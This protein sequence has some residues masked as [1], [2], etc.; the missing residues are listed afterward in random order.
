MVGS[1]FSD[2]SPD[3]RPVNIEKQK[4]LKANSDLWRIDGVHALRLFGL[5]TVVVAYRW[6]IF[7]ALLRLNINC[8]LF[9][10][11]SEFIFLIRR[12]RDC[13]DDNRHTMNSK[14]TFPNLW[15]QYRHF[16]ELFARIRNF[17]D[18]DASYFGGSMHSLH[19]AVPYFEYNP[20]SLLYWMHWR[21]FLCAV[22]YSYRSVTQV[23]R[24][25]VHGCLQSR[26]AYSNL[27]DVVNMFQ[28]ISN[29][30]VTLYTSIAQL[31]SDNIKIYSS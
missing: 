29:N 7:S 25:I 23:H 4:F 20:R 21:V 15:L 16:F 6:N 10:A 18:V 3:I 17:L 30:R 26:S 1:A 13:D 31:Y 5:S 19:S 28:N 12:R 24:H 22:Q 27:G 14:Y 11:S 2:R 8:E 9:T